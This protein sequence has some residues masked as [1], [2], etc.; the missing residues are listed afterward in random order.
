MKPK[1]KLHVAPEPAAP[2]LREITEA[3][4]AR[5]Y[6]RSTFNQRAWIAAVA[7]MREDQTRLRWVLDGSPSKWKA[8]L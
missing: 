8:Q 4:A 7:W 2:V 3:D 5:M 1:P 6:P